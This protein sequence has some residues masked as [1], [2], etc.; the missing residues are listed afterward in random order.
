MFRLGGLIIISATMMVGCLE[1]A[2]ITLPVHT[3]TNQYQK[4]LNM[5]TDDLP[6]MRYEVRVDDCL[7]DQ[8][9]AITEAFEAWTTFN[10]HFV[11]SDDTRAIYMYCVPGD[12]DATSL[13]AGWSDGVG[14][15]FKQGWIKRMINTPDVVHAYTHELGHQIGL[16][17]VEDVNA[18]MAPVITSSVYWTDADLIEYR[19]TLGWL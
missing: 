7:S 1:P 18:I 6:T 10:V 17:H 13:W 11:L 16:R 3:R 14:I 8:M 12:A 9:D 19:R 5:S 2:T 4:P 15:R